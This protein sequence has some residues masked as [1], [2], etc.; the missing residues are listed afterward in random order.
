MVQSLVPSPLLNSINYSSLSS[1]NHRR[2]SAS[3]SVTVAL[4]SLFPLCLQSHYPSSCL[5][6]SPS[7]IFALLLFL[8]PGRLLLCCGSGCEVWPTTQLAH[9]SLESSVP[10]CLLVPLRQFHLDPAGGDTSSAH[11]AASIAPFE[12]CIELVIYDVCFL[13]QIWNFVILRQWDGIINVN[14]NEAMDYEVLNYHL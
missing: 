4:H 14:K 10:S 2:V 1:S 3:I 12:S 5:L 6:Q 7:L 9:T 8:L 11:L 13:I